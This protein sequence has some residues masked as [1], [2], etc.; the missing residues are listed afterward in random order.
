LGW[1][2]GAFLAAYQENR[3]E[4][5]ATAIDNN[6]VAALILQFMQQGEEWRGTASELILALRNRFP[7]ETESAEA[8]PRTSQ[9]FGTELSRVKPLLSRRGVTV[10]PTREGKTG[11]RVIVLKAN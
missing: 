1:P 4:S 5:E 3:R 7:V 2:E 11:R 6:M 9:R 10:E 8:F